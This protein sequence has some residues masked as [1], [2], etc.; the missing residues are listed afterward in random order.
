MAYDDLIQAA[1]KQNGIDPRLLTAVIRTESSF[2]PQAVNAETGAAGLGQMLP[3]TA[4]SLGVK[5]PKDPNEAIPGTAKLL[6][7]N[8]QR[9]G[10]EDGVRAYHGGTDR[11]NWGPKTEAYVNKV[12]AAFQGGAPS[13]GL[14]SEFDSTPASTKGAPAFANVQSSLQS[15]APAAASSGLL[16]EFDQTPTQPVAP[17]ASNVASAA[18]VNTG[19]SMPAAIQQVRQWVAEHHLGG[20]PEDFYNA[21]VH[22]LAKPLH[23]AAQLLGHGV[24]GGVNLVAP[25]SSVAGAANQAMGNYDTSLQNWE[26]AYQA[27]TPTNAASVVGAGGGQVIPLM[28]G[29]AGQKLAEAGDYAASLIPK[30]PQALRPYVSA[31]GQG[32][33]LGAIQPVTDGSGSFG[34]DKLHQVEL[35]ALTGGALHAATSA[36]GTLAQAAKPLMDPVGYVRENWLPKIVG[37]DKQAIIDALRQ[38]PEYV[39]GSVPTSAQAAANPQLAMAEKALSNQFPDFKIALMDRANANNAARTAQLRS[40]A[41]TQDA[42]DLMAAD[43]KAAVGPWIDA[44]LSD[45]RPIVRWGN[46][47]NVLDDVL[48]KPM[49]RGNDFNALQDAQ[50]VIGA[51]KSGKI[52][53]DDALESLKELGD[54]VSGKK[55]QA[56]FANVF[57]EINRNMVDPTSVLNTL[58]TIRYGS[59][60]VNPQRAATLD[61]LISQ[62]ENGRNI[63]GMIGTDVLDAV[64][65][66]ASKALGNATPQSAIAYGPAKD[67]ITQAIDRVAPGYSNYLADYRVMSQPIT[68]ARAAS[69]I[70]DVL[71]SRGLNS[72]GQPQLTLS[73][74][75]GPLKQALEGDYPLSAQAQASLKGVQRDLQRDTIS[76]SVRS[77]GSDTVANI[78]ANNWLTK[79][80]YGSDFGGT[81]MLPKLAGG[82]LGSLNPLVGAL[83]GFMGAAK[84]GQK[85]A[86]RIGQAAA[87]IM[88]DPKVMA[89]Q[90]DLLQKTNPQAAQAL[91]RLLTQEG[92]S[93]SAGKIPS[94]AQRDALARRLSKEN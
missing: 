81:G 68:D 53:E 56:A 11:A 80:L 87:D 70:L 6:A 60:G 43:R 67:Q 13:S 19:S 49:N 65:Q 93:Q 4:A 72:A 18:S 10:V 39:P 14:L 50:K 58:K 23:G 94:Q 92:S 55:A 41:G 59:M 48:S 8:I 63:N 90:L 40:L 36:I 88:L 61:S 2:N 51:V 89:D 84:I 35:G 73:N 64:R 85:G 77:P 5:N 37:G 66:E 7:E 31:A 12:S 75:N 15:T 22:N 17:S 57:S 78:G 28:A 62:V 3:S 32:A 44:N 79:S 33:A 42:M 24:A 71:D 52:Q 91:Q 21:A 83:G 74:F 69:G 54:S 27:Q 25:G 76:S 34:A 38:A 86:E 29:G 26:N 16:S 9:F 20:P 82:A 46:A 45:S 30:L 1:A 47:G